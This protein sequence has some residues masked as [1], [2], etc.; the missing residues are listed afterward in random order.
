MEIMQK[1]GAPVPCDGFPLTNLKFK[2]WLHLKM[3]IN[4]ERLLINSSCTP[5]VD[6]NGQEYDNL[7]QKICAL[8]AI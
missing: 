7:I 1:M 2:T 3:L 8:S 5:P 6:C 4:V